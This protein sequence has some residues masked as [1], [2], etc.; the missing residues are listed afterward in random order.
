MASILEAGRTLH[1][2]IGQAETQSRR[3]QDVAL[4]MERQIDRFKLE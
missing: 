1:D 3:S 2:V 4:E